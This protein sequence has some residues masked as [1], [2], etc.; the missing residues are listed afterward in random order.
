MFR[1]RQIEYIGW[2]KTRGGPS[3]K[4]VATGACL[5]SRFRRQKLTNPTQTAGIRG[6]TQSWRRV[7]S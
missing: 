6:K 1:G 7:F 5:S 2:Q 3:K 4:Q